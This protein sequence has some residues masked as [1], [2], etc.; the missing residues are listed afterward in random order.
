MIVNNFRSRFNSFFHVSFYIKV[1]KE[2]I[3]VRTF[4]N[5]SWIRCSTT[6]EVNADKEYQI[7]G[8][9]SI[10]THN[11][12]LKL[13]QRKGLTKRVNPFNHPRLVYPQ[14][15]ITEGFIRFLMKQHRFGWWKS[16]NCI[17][18]ELGYYPEGGLTDVES[19]MLADS[20][21]H[22]GAKQCY[23]INPSFKMTEKEIDDLCSIVNSSK[24]KKAKKLSSEMLKKLSH[25]FS[26][27]KE[28]G[29]GK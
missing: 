16:V 14:F 5:E 11:I 22:C 3:Y 18:L 6:F 17:I 12:D 24:I 28:N 20:L 21:E 8:I 19:K 4:E 25:P 9:S 29:F 27:L 15:G 26:N 7:V 1:D 10:E 2:R 23:I 13:V